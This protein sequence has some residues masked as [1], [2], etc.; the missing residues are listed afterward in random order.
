Y[1]VPLESVVEC[2]EFPIEEQR[3]ATRQQFIN[4][5][6]EVLPFIQLSEHFNVA[7]HVKGRRQNIIVVNHGGKK[8]GLVVDALHGE[9]QTVIKP[10]G[11][12]FAHLQGLAGSTIMGNGQVALILDVAALIEQ[13][14][15]V[16]EDRFSNKRKQF[17]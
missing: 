7:N 4:L 16:E 17:H 3:E 8:V 10:L 9:H 13:V 5:R 14:A 2:I 11:R 12:L 1:V 15:T 6:S